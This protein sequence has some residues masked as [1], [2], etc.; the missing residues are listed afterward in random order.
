MDKGRIVQIGTPTEVYEFPKN[1]FVA[2]FIGSINM[3]E[4]VV[5]RSRRDIARCGVA[6]ARHHGCRPPTC[7]RLAVGHEVALAVRPEK[8]AISARRPDGRQ[9]PVRRGRGLAYFG[10]DSLYR[11][12]LPTGIVLSVNSVNARARGEH[13]RV[14]DWEDQ[15][16]LSFEPSAAIL[17]LE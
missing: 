13:E 11:V 4:G 10:K 9:R 17:L 15:V 14:A 16:W 1:R 3:F 12:R 5:R 2:D 7:P 6:G 8:I